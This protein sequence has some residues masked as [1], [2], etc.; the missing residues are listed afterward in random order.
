M[1]RILFVPALLALFVSCE[2]SVSYPDNIK[3]TNKTGMTVKFWTAENNS[4]E[5]ELPAYYSMNLPSDVRGRTQISGIEAP[6]VTWEHNNNSE[7]DIW[8]IKKGKDLEIRN[9]TNDTITVKEKNRY[10]SKDGVW[11]VDEEV[12]IGPKKH[13]NYE[14]D[15]LNLQLYTKKPVW[16]IEPQKRFELIKIPPDEGDNFATY[17]LGIEPPYDDEEWYLK[18][19]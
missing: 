19:E 2:A 10:I 5:Y 6:L 1:K 15:G 8:L 3:Y 9:Y 7:Y 14:A 12:K 17:I 18:Q 16:I 4:P 13:R 11:P